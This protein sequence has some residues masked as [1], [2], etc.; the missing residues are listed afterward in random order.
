MASV[1][2]LSPSPIDLG[3]YDIS[4]PFRRSFSSLASIKSDGTL[5]TCRHRHLSIS[6]VL[7]RSSSYAHPT[8]P[9]SDFTFVPASTFHLNRDPSP[10][11]LSSCSDLSASPSFAPTDYSVSLIELPDEQRDK[12]AS[13]DQRVGLKQ[14]T[15]GDSWPCLDHETSSRNAHIWHEPVETHDDIDLSF[16][17]E[18]SA[19][20][21]PT[22]HAQSQAF[23]RWVSTLRRR[24]PANRTDI[25][26]PLLRQAAFGRDPSTAPDHSFAEHRRSGSYVSS[27]AFVT[28][29]RSASM[30]MTTTSLPSVDASASIRSPKS[31]MYIK[32]NPASRTDLRRSMDSESTSANPVLDDAALRRA[33]KRARKIQELVK[34][35][36]SY[37]SDLKCLQNA[38]FT[39]LLPH[40]SSSLRVVAT[41]ACVSDLLQLHEDILLQL[42]IVIRQLTSGRSGSKGQSRAANRTKL[43]P[44][45]ASRGGSSPERR[46]FP[47]RGERSLLGGFLDMCGNFEG[48]DCEP[49]CTPQLAAEVARIFTTKTKRFA[50]YE[51]YGVRCDT[52]QLDVD[53]QRTPTSLDYDRAL[54]ALQATVCPLQD[55]EKA[56]RKA[57]G[58]KDLLIKPVQRIT[59]YELLFKDLCTLTPSCDDPSSHAVLDDALFVISQTCHDLNEAS[60]SAERLKVLDSQRRLEQKLHFDMKPVDFTFHDF[61]RLLLCG[62]LYIAYRGTANTKGQYAI[63]VLYESCLIIATNGPG[64]Y[65]VLLGISLGHASIEESDN[66]KSL[67]CHTTPHAWKIVFENE[68]ALFEILCVACSATEAKSWRHNISGRIAVESQYSDEGRTGGIEIPSPITDEM[69]SVGKAYGRDAH[70]KRRSS[71]QRA[72]TLGPLT[73]LNQVIIKNTQAAGKDTT[74]S[75]SSLPIPRSQSV[76]TPSHIPVLAPRRSDRIHLEALLVDVWTK[77]AL[78]FPGLGSKKGE[79]SVRA[80]AN[81]VIRKLSIASI[82]SNFSKRS[83]SFSNTSQPPLDDRNAR[84]R[85]K[86]RNPPPKPPKKPM[87]RKVINFHTA[88]EAFL[89]EDF[90]LSNPAKARGRLG[91]LRTFTMGSERPRGGFFVTEN[92][93]SV[94]SIKRSHSVVTRRRRSDFDA[95][96]LV[97]DRSQTAM[98]TPTVLMADAPTSREQSTSDG[99]IGGSE[100][101]PGM[102]QRAKSKLARLLG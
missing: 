27:L 5:H 56:S 60:G 41:Q 30:T 42:Q 46:P 71:V 11:R 64:K 66:G 45:S 33:H 74:T 92:E 7:T 83:M 21:R 94:S 85:P 78:P 2:S 23:K 53:L 72:A 10:S 62:A 26:S 87:E 58:L 70:F 17:E 22:S 73:E 32:S 86:P 35:E 25:K 29:A 20:I 50:V 4:P 102:R 81:H 91:G 16:I 38:Y 65:R 48:D 82:T 37:L 89:P 34:T 90:E 99:Q 1:L 49:L 97:A 98:S 79:Y 61:G 19:T 47:V 55:R 14:Q 24:N 101:R 67:Q 93:Q 76:L 36:E 95:D 12:P 31:I 40:T 68:G 84:I 3:G 77:D 80:S 8:Q 59:R 44:Y 54:E 51:E 39:I 9:K 75:S 28:G 52:M 57:L 15:Y 13:E 18:T 43:Q 6:S 96:K 100:V 69:R 63:C 88:P